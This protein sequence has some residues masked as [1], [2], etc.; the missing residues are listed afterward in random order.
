MAAS[1]PWFDCVVHALVGQTAGAL[2][3]FSCFSVFSNLMVFPP[4]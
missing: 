2:T 1:K 3:L 4:Q